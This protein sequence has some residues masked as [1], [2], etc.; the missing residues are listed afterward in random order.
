MIT[1]A[2]FFLFLGLIVFGPEKT[3]EM[4]QMLARVLAQ[5]KHGAAQF[6]SQIESEIDTRSK[7]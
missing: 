7:S 3:V 2:A 4:A 5:V 6:Q 1:A